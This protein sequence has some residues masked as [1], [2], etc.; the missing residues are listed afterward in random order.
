MQKLQTIREHHIMTIHKNSRN[1]GSWQNTDLRP[2]KASGGMK[3]NGIFKKKKTNQSTTNGKKGIIPS[4]QN[5][6]VKLFDAKSGKLLETPD[7]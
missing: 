7:I 1:K 4:S 3:N 5:I 6:K 2:H